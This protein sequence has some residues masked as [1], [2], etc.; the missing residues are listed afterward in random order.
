MNTEFYGLGDD[1]DDIVTDLPLS[2]IPG[3]FQ[4]GSPII[5]PT[6]AVTYAGLTTT[7]WLM[8]GGAAVALFFFI[9]GGRR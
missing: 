7:Q 2:P 4:G 3:S 6:V 8:I 1:S 5:T 9:P